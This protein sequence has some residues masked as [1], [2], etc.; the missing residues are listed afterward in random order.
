MCSDGTNPLIKKGLYRC[1]DCGLHFASR[2]ALGG[3]RR[4]CDGTAEADS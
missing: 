1:N 4:N 2:A 3:H